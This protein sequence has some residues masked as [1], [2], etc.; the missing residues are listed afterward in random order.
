MLSRGA[1][2]LFV[3]VEVFAAAV[4][5]LLLGFVAMV[6][7]AL[8]LLLLLRAALVALLDGAAG[9]DWRER[10]LVMGFGFVLDVVCVC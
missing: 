10:G 3:F 4:D 2:L 8:L 7:A 9:C 5:G 1:L 6:V